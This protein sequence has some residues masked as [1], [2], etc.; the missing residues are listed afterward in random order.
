MPDNLDKPF[1]RSTPALNIKREYW[2]EV[3]N[4]PHFIVELRY[5]GCNINYDD[6]YFDNLNNIINKLEAL[7]KSRK[8]RVTLDGGHRF[9][10]TLEAAVTGGITIYFQAESFP[11]TFPGK[12]KLK[13]YFAVEGE[14]TSK[15][16]KDLIKLFKD[17]KEFHAQSPTIHNN[18]L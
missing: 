17:G 11:P 14:Y 15:I 7:E 4:A 10:A 8:G 16:I 6:I 9:A 18:L 3:T 1:A 2:P 5:E 13:G 12:L